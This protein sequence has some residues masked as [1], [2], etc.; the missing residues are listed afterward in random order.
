L[1]V[2]KSVA[3]QSPA[4]PEWWPL[5]DP[6]AAKELVGAAHSNLKRVQEIV[7]RQPYIVNASIDWGYGDWEDPLGAAAHTGRREIAGFLLENGA[8]MSIFAAAM[9]GQLEVV[10]AF[11]AANPGIQRTLGPHGIPL[12]AHAQAGGPASEPVAKYLESL[13]DAGRRTPTQPLEDADRDSLVGRYV[14]GTAPRDEIRIELRTDMR[15]SI[16]RPG[17]SARLLYHA[18]NLVFYPSGAPLVKIAFI[19]ANGKVTQ[20]TVSDPYVLLTAK[21]QA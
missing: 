13:G 17:T 9:L 3:A 12:L 8:R 20:L 21:R 14:F 2:P 1:A 16:E 19:R 6:E 7:E 4:A 5:Q 10:K 18:G 11:V 15:L